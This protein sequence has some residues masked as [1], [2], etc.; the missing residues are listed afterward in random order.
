MVLGEH[1]RWV[2][3]GTE[4]ETDVESLIVHELYDPFTADNDIALFKLP[5]DIEYNRN[6][7]PICLPR[8]DVEPNTLCIVTGWGDTKCK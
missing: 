3:E 5:F 8:D 4:K 7:K 6:M 1:N 2:D